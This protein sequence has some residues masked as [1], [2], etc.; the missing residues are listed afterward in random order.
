MST[1]TAVR[2]ADAFMFHRD[3][4]TMPRDALA[5]QQ[6][7]R[8]RRTLER[9]YADVPHYRKAFDRVGVKPADFKVL[10]DIA[11]FPF[12]MKTDLRDNYPFGMFAVPRDQLVRADAARPPP[13]I[14]QGRHPPAPRESPSS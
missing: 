7:I 14:S 11:R 10:A 5:G 13:N 9:A 2:S 8:L 6:T 4:E 1:H 3:A 12:T